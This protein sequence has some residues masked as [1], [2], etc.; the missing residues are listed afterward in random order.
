MSHHPAGGDSC[1][2]GRRAGG[3]FLIKL[4]SGD[5]VDGQSDPD[6]VLLSFGHQVLDD[7]GALLVIQ[8]RTNLEARGLN[9]RLSL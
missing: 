4:V 8:G 1:G 3:G 7:G 6:L 5:K 2:N 9:K